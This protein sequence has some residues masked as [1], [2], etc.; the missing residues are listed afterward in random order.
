MR[1]AFTVLLVAFVPAANCRYSA[2]NLPVVPAPA[3]VATVTDIQTGAPISGATLTLTEG[4]VTET[5]LEGSAGTYA[6]RSSH[7]GTFSLT[8]QATGFED[9][10]MDNITVTGQPCAVTTVG[11]TVQMNPL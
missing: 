10:T 9:V 6:G 1:V 5:M 2:C 8:A 7:P 4:L 11:L 3:I